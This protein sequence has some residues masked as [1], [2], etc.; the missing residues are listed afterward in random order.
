MGRSKETNMSKIEETTFADT[1]LFYFSNFILNCGFVEEDNLSEKIV[2][3]I[4][5]E[6]KLYRDNIDDIGN[7]DRFLFTNQE[8]GN[9]K[10]DNDGGVHTGISIK[11][12]RRFTVAC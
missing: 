5:I 6:E 12:S 2:T 7:L 1:D 3:V 4:V 10:E 8:C 9:L 11:K